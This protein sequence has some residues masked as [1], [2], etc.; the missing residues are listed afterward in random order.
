LA[1]LVGAAAQKPWAAL[2]LLLPYTPM[3]FMGQEFVASSRFYY[4]TDHK[5]E[6]GRQIIEGRRQEFA[7][8]SGFQDA[9]HAT[10]I[11]DPQAEQ[12]FLDSKLNLEEREEG[13]GAERWALTRELIAL[14]KRDHVLRRQDRRSMRAVAASDSMLLVHL[15]HGREH[16]LVVANFGMAVDASPGNAG[17]PE[18]LTRYDWR[19]VLSTEERRFGGTDDRV[20]FDAQMVA[21]PPQTVAWL[22]ATEPSPPVRALRFAVGVWRRSL[23]VTGTS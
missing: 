16:R 17:V 15:W 7:T 21:I 1:H 14:R 8:F 18:E 4:F 12:T 22:T 6:L 13:V 3:L 19:V 9:E 11:P 20:R 23:G 5:E 10:E 2:Q